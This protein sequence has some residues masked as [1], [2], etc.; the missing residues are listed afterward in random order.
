[1]HTPLNPRTLTHKIVLKIAQQQQAN[2][3]IFLHSDGSI[4][5]GPFHYKG[6]FKKIFQQFYS[7]IIRLARVKPIKGI[8]D[9]SQC[10]YWDAISIYDI[11]IEANWQNTISATKIR[12]LADET[13]I[14]TLIDK[15]SPEFKRAATAKWQRIFRKTRPSN[16][17][18][19]KQ[20]WE[21]FT[22]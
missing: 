20:G 10:K 14:R 4:S 9:V 8:L 11:I 7:E 12:R 15:I 13:E 2:Q 21:L 17:S 1:M 22:C 16:T 3:P 5:C 18:T 19:L 6:R